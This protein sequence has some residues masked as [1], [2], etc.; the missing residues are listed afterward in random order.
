MIKKKYTLLIIFFFSISLSAQISELKIAS[1][2]LESF[3][4]KK[5][6]K[7]FFDSI[8]FMKS[9]IKKSFE[10][11][12]AVGG[13]YDSR[14]IKIMFP[15]D[16]DKIKKSLTKLGLEKKVVKFEKQMNIVAEQSSKESVN[17]FINTI[18]TLRFDEL[19]FDNMNR[20]ATLTNYLR[21]NSS[22][23]IYDSMSP[24]IEKEI[25]N[26]KLI[27]DYNFLIKKYNKIPFV[28]K[29]KFDIKEYVV[30]KTLEGIFILIAEEE[31]KIK[32]KFFNTN[33]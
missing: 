24:I 30:T 13:F 16:L 29:I 6:D 27:E 2:K 15:K 9:I 33:K 3:I 22:I 5:S 31:K 17:V 7:D 32:N 8:S 19:P 28:K 14:I 1:E 11:A 25:I 4:N 10:K 26:N 21:N 18:S 12:S 23:A 20:S